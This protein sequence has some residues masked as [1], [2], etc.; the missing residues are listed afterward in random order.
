VRFGQEM[1][2]LDAENAVSVK[3]INGFSEVNKSWDGNTLCLSP[4][5]A[6]TPGLVYTVSVSGL[7]RTKDGREDNIEKR[8]SFVWGAISNIPFVSS[9]YPRNGEKT[10]VSPEDGAFVRLYFSKEMDA[11]SVEEAFVL[12]GFQEKE[13]VWT[14]RNTVV[15]IRN[16]KNIEPF[17]K[18]SWT[19]KTSANSHEGFNLAREVAAEWTSDK[20]AE[21]P[22]V[23]RAAP[24]MKTDLSL[25]TGEW[26]ETGN[27][28]EEGP[29]FGEGIKLVFSKRMDNASVRSCVRFEPS[30]AGRVEIVNAKEI[31]FVPERGFST[32]V[33]YTMTVSGETKDEYGIR[34]GEDYKACFT[35][36]IAYLEAVFINVSNNLPGADASSED[37][38]PFETAEINVR[39]H[40]SEITV[41]IEFS[42]PFTSENQLDCLDRMKLVKVFPNDAPIPSIKSEECSAVGNRV[43][44]AVWSGFYD[45]Y[46]HNHPHFY[47]LTIPGGSSGITNG[48]GAFLQE[49]IVLFIKVNIF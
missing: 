16:K 49:D 39:D 32:D 1:H 36:D 23:L 27:T 37:I 28:M 41:Q 14:E 10:G 30:V 3:S 5:K 19:L 43:F 48:N 45:V 42:V 25:L 6:W 18:F 22:A 34:M 11:L 40:Q 46:T 38:K 13:F 24:V 15:E 12:G 20:D 31:V 35:P 21:R 33:F 8:L 29:G 26:I 7:L 47:K 9:F 4:V 2:T 44:K 17:T